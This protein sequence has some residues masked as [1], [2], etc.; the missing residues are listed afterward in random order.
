MK[1]DKTAIMEETKITEARKILKPC[2]VKQGEIPGWLSKRIRAYLKRRD[3]PVSP[4]KQFALHEAF[5][6]I[7][8]EAGI[9]DTF[10]R[11]FDHWGTSKGGPYV[12]CNEAGRCFVTEPYGFGPTKALMTDAFCKALG[13]TWH[14]SSNS[15]WNPGATVCVSIHELTPSDVRGG[16]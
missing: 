13:L 8:H 2:E 11:L 14:V 5:H 3:I 16:K 12:C 4:C 10:E 9:D 1:K 15:W 7:V 6:D